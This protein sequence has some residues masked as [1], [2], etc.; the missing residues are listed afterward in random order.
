MTTKRNKT[1]KTTN[2]PQTKT[3]GAGSIAATS[4]VNAS[5]ADASSNASD[6]NTDKTVDNNMA[7]VVSSPQ[8]NN[9]NT[10]LTN[11]ETHMDTTQ[12]QT[13]NGNGQLLTF[14]RNDKQRRSNM[15]VFDA[16]EGRRG[17]VRI[18]KTLFGKDQV[19][20]TVAI[21]HPNFATPKVPYAKMSAEERK[22]ARLA[23]PK[24]TP[25]EKLAR[26]EEKIAKL[27]AKVTASQN[28]GAGEAQQAQT[29][30]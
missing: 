4:S 19:P 7:G 22:A 26:A 12:A 11:G 20:Q 9:S 10:S 18:S 21:E 2:K 6:S 28:A 17:S 3:T 24:L 25:A 8:T 29:T 16:P 15:V 5:S 13:S 1:T 23:R 30:M 14:T 27:R